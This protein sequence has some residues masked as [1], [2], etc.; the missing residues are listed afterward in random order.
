LCWHIGG[1]T[2]SFGPV[3]AFADG[4]G[5]L[6]YSHAS[7]YAE[8]RETH[9]RFIAERILPTG[10][11][12]DVG[13]GIV[14]HGTSLSEAFADRSGALAYR[15]HRQEDGTVSEEVLPTRRLKR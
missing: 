7:H 4:L 5:L 9:Q 2:D 14:Y 1:T 8:R 13:A 11:A 15:L 3:K 12:A 10:S 6:P